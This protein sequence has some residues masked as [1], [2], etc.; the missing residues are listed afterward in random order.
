MKLFDLLFL[1]EGM[2]KY[3]KTLHLQMVEFAML[4]TAGFVFSRKTNDRY[5]Q[6]QL[7]AARN[8]WE[9]YR[10]EAISLSM[11][12]DEKYIKEFDLNLD[13]WGYDFQ[14]IDQFK[15]NKTNKIPKVR[16]RCT[17][18]FDT[19]AN[20]TYMGF[21]RY[22]SGP[23]LNIIIN[24][25]MNFDESDP[26]TEKQN[27]EDTLRHELGHLSQDLLRKLKIGEYENESIEKPKE[28]RF[29]VPSRS[30]SGAGERDLE[31]KAKHKLRDIEFY[32]NLGDSLAI[33]KH[34]LKSVAQDDKNLFFKTF[35]G[36]I[37]KRTETNNNLL[38]LKNNNKA[39]W[40][41]AVKEL[42]KEIF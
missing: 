32:T 22:S 34:S 9:E 26:V 10:E 15:D 11:F 4:A 38:A 39:K 1:N 17:F 28:H 25:I 2:L 23:V 19:F 30:I 3:P 16:L 5:L 12:G 35:V 18:L 27:I 21:M 31:T 7:D 14:S 41:K 29:G 6:K 36:I 40:H 13:D 20:G 24:N 8:N 37:E 33:L 42:Y